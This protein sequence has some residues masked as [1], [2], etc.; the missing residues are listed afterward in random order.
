MWFLN[1]VRA[2]ME[3][4]NA[5]WTVGVVAVILILAVYCRHHWVRYGWASQVRLGVA[6]GVLLMG[7]VVQRSTIWWWHHLFNNGTRIPL[8]E[9]YFPLA[10]GCLFAITGIF[11]SIRVLSESYWGWPSCMKVSVGVLM[12]AGLL[13]IV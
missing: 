1:T 4:L 10:I 8:D 12:I 13:V 11:I 7:D 5:V 6:L 2:N 3:V 9:F